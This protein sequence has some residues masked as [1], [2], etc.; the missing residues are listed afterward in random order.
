M[1]RADCNEDEQ[2]VGDTSDPAIEASPHVLEEEG[3]PDPEEGDADHLERAEAVGLGLGR[4]L[5]ERKKLASATRG[6]REERT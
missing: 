5:R 3:V 2:R 4:E 6:E 1:D